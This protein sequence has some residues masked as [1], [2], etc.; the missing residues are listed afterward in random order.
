[1]NAWYVKVNWADQAAIPIHFGPRNLFASLRS[2]T[3]LEKG[4]VM[5]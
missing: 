1:M 2:P 4:R 5:R 3:G